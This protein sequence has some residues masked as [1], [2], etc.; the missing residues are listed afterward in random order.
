MAKK[1]SFGT[2]AVA[3][4]DPSVDMNGYSGFFGRKRSKA[5]FHV[6][7]TTGVKRIAHKMPSVPV[8]MDS[9][10]QQVA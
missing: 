6:Q 3:I 7:S 9:A 5:L 4:I 2:L 1:P 10:H 8:R